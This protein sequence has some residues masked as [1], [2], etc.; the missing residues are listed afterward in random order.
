MLIV[1]LVIERKSYRNIRRHV[2]SVSY[3]YLYTK[4]FG[5]EIKMSNDL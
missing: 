4:T 5:A 1:N 2:S 3:N